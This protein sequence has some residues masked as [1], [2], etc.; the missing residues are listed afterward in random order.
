VADSKK[1]TPPTTE[2]FCAQDLIRRHPHLLTTARI[3]WAVRNRR[4]NGLQDAVY[5]T[6]S[7]HLVIHEPQFLRWYLGLTGRKKPRA[8]R[9]AKEK[10]LPE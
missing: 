5:V 1:C 10:G 3:Q 6:K 7:G 2:L 9:R 4:K 8:A